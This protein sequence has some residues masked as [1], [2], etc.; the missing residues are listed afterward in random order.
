MNEPK[1]I[2]LQ[3]ILDLHDLQVQAHG[4]S[5][6]VRDLG[7]L[8]SALAQPQQMFCYQEPMPGL[9]E[10]AACY[11]HGICKNHP[12]IDGNKRSAL[13]ACTLFLAINGIKTHYPEDE[14]YHMFRAVAAG[15]ASR[16]ELSRWLRHHSKISHNIPIAAK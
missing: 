2:N 8:Q 5:H 14:A 7:L 11:A 4:G 3:A 12:F 15:I 1:W 13:I 9:Y 10:L 6:G 16:E